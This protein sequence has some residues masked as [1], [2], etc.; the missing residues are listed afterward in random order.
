MTRIS[1]VT[2][3]SGGIGRAV[4]RKLAERG[5]AVAMLAR[6][7][8]GLEGAAEDVRRAGGTPLPIEVDVADFAAVDEAAEQVEKDLGPIDLWVNDAFS[9]VFAPFTEISMDEFTRITQ[10]SY[11]GYVYGTRAALS[12]M[13]PRDRG[14][15]VQVGSALAYRGIPLQTAYCGAKHAIQGFHEALRVEL[16]HDKSNVHVTM[17]QMPAVNTPQFGWVLSR[18]PNRAQP[19][20]PIYQPEI[21]A[22]AVVYAAEHP[23]RREYWVGG[24]T[25]GTLLANAVAPGLLDRYLARTGFKSQQTDQKRDSDQPA[26]LWH[27]VDSERG[28][29][30]GAHGDFDA[31]AKTRSAQVWASQH[32]GTLAAVAGG[33]A[34][35]AWAIRRA[36]AR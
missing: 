27:P 20:P 22:Q 7:A 36:V 29:D 4:V 23:K 11:L 34:A 6:G 5:D 21:A 30:E 17:V 25:A 33:V 10:V 16:M 24:S 2:G 32:H 9:S 3:A 12:R 14:T 28:P 26:N 35:A 13:L 31:Q 15:I 19:V 18:L 8:D 1:V